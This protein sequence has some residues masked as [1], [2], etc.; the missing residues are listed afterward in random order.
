MAIQHD[1]PEN[2]QLA[3]EKVFSND[4]LSPIT[5][6]NVRENLENLLERMELTNDCIGQNKYVPALLQGVTSILEQN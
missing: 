5:E 2:F 4:R 1:L 3:F 6:E